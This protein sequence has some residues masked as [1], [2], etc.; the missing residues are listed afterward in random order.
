MDVATT[1]AALCK[2]PGAYGNSQLREQL[3]SAIQKH[4]DSLERTKL[5][6][7]LKVLNR[8]TEQYDFATALEAMEEAIHRGDGTIAEVTLLAA[9][10]THYGLMTKPESGPDLRQYDLALLGGQA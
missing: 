4:L 7:A 5:K 2:A 3:P 6:E 10:L 9:R 8:V 1:L